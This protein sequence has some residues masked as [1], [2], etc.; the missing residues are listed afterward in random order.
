MAIPQHIYQGAPVS[1]L[2]TSTVKWFEA[3]T[4][5]HVSVCLAF[6]TTTITLH[7]S[8]LASGLEELVFIK[9]PKIFLSVCS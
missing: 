5:L 8:D 4:C 6:T 1:C 2:A 7:L 9:D 3:G